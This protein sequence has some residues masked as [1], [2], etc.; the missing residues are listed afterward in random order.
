V[1]DIDGVKRTTT[2][3]VMGEFVEYRIGQLIAA[4]PGRRL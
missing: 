2:N 1:L 3:L 4:V